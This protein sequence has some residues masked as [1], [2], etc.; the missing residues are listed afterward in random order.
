VVLRAAWAYDPELGTMV[1]LATRMLEGGDALLFHDT[2]APINARLRFEEFAAHA[3]RHDL[4]Y[5]AEANYWEMQLG[6]LP[7][8]LRPAALEH[9]DRLPREGLLDEL[10]MRTFRQTLLCHA[11]QQVGEPAP[12]RLEELAVASQATSSAGA[13]EG[14]VTF[15]GS[16]GASLT[17]DHR[18][19]IDALQRVTQAWPAA[20]AVASLWPPDAGAEHRAV[21]CEAL[22]RCY[23]GAVVELRAEPSAAA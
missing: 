23:G 18:L 8:E 19:V 5:L 14:A 21:I 17:T 11:A 20:L 4:Q 22:L 2:L 10:R 13:Q 7:R 1:G 12:Q 16:S 9:G 15:T 6:W 3:A